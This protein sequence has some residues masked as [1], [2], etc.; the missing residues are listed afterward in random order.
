LWDLSGIEEDA[1]LM[2]RIGLKLAHQD[3]FPKWKSDSEFKAIRD[4]QMAS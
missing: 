4:K 2:F 3:T 1:K